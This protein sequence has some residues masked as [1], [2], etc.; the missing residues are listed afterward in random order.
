MRT[1]ISLALVLLAAG[2][3]AAWAAGDTARKGAAPTS[4]AVIADASTSWL[5]FSSRVPNLDDALAREART[6]GS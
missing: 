2:A 4:V 1:L 6:A 5:E 3:L